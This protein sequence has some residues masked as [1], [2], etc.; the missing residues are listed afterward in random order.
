MGIKVSIVGATGNVGREFLS[1]LEERK[2]PI[3]ELFLLAS[4]NSEGKKISFGKKELKVLDLKKFDFKKCQLVFS[5]AGSKVSSEFLPKAAKAGCYIIDNS[6]YFRMDPDVPL[7][8][9]EVNSDD[10]KNIKKR[11]IANP[12]CSTIQM[13]M[14]LKPL[15]NLVP[16]KR[17]VVS[18]YQS[19][20]GAGRLAMDELFDQTKS[21]FGNN[22]IKK[23][24]FTKQIA[25]N[26]IPHIDS[27]LEDG[28]TK[29]EWKM[30]VETQ[31]IM[32]ESIKVTATCVRVPV[33][34]G[35]GE[36]VNIEFEKEITEDK[37]R[38]VLKKSPGIS[39]VDFRKDEGYVTP[40]ECAGEDK[41]Y[42]S[43]IRKDNTLKNAISLWVVA[44]NLRKGAALN[45]IQIG[46]ELIK[47]KF[48]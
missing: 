24:S 30:E 39:V 5:S 43:R 41:V 10:L 20:S 2:F 33:F 22:P 11:I 40:E 46:E 38:D 17:V 7:V 16:I 25:F 9:P 29:E 13:V 21:I 3:D 18:T 4:S 19:T 42:V 14:V 23:K 6:S 35:H 28:K 15:H 8:V 12:N 37:L 31:K 48:F 27:F 26:V 34:I 1:I 45:A 47:K 36:S 44:D 32:D